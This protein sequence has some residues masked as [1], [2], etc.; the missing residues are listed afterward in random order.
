MGSRLAIAL[1]AT[2]LVVA[3][4]AASPLGGAAGNASKDLFGNTTSPNSINASPETESPLSAGGHA[5]AS[6]FPFFNLFAVVA[7]NGT[8]SQ[9]RGVVS[10]TRVATGTY[11]VTFFFNVTRCAWL[12]TIGT[13]TGFPNEDRGY[14]EHIRVQSQ[15]GN[16]RAVRVFLRLEN[17]ADV[18]VP[19][20]DGFHLAVIC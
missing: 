14:A 18:D 8:A 16:P 11:V 17:N 10:S 7:L 13:F 20:N 19:V 5:R 3:V 4:L 12:A 6:Q 15:P 2:A 9:G 1:S